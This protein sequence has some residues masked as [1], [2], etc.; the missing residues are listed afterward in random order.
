MNTIYL[1]AT[2]LFLLA[3]ASLFAWIMS[4]QRL[5]T[6]CPSA[7]DLL[8]LPFVGLYM[9]MLLVPCWVC[10]CVEF[11]VPCSEGEFGE[12]HSNPQLSRHPHHSTT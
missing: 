7:S 11:L 9:L 12:R 3:C 10:C 8:V 1:Y 5:R 6:L 4:K 2:P